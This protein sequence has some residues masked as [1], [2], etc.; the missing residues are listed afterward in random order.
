MQYFGLNIVEDV[1][2]SWEEAE[3]SWVEVGGAG[4]R[5]MDL[6]G[7]QWRWMEVRGGGCMV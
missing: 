2:E 1:A 7:T 4:W 6:V 3:M 5:R